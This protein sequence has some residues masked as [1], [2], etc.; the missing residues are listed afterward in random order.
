LIYDFLTR[1]YEQIEDRLSHWRKRFG[2]RALEALEE[3]TFNDLE[4]NDTE[5]RAMW[6]RWALSGDDDA[7]H[8]FYYLTHVNKGSAERQILTVKVRSLYY[9][10]CLIYYPTHS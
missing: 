5:N 7:S 6:C 8:P 2:E 4:T 10:L 3:I 1:P 9:H